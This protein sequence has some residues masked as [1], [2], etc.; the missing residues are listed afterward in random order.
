MERPALRQQRGTQP[1]TGSLD[2]ACSLESMTIFGRKSAR[3]AKPRN[4]GSVTPGVSVSEPVWVRL[5]TFFIRA[6]LQRAQE[7]SQ[8]ELPLSLFRSN[9]SNRSNIDSQSRSAGFCRA[10]TKK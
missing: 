10:V 9:R 1:A 2:G 7:K 6:C 4:A 8:F 3:R 5:L